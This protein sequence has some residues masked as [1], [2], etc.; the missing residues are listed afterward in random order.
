MGDLDKPRQRGNERKSA[1]TR[2][3]CGCNE[4]AALG[5]LYLFGILALL[6]TG[7]GP[8]SLFEWCFALIGFCITLTAGKL[9]GIGLARVRIFRQI[10]AMGNSI[11]LETRNKE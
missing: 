3:A 9:A 11:A 8:G 5:L 2:S 6:I 10:R 1:R 7:R 4:G